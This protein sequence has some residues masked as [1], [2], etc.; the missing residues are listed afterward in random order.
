MDSK[1][2]KKGVDNNLVPIGQTK[3]GRGKGP[4]K[5]K[6]KSKDSTS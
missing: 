3:K 4:K 2:E 1:H 5:G 6:G